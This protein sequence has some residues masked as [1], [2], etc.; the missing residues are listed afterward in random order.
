MVESLSATREGDG[1][2]DES[3]AA[4]EKK[5]KIEEENSPSSA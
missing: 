5:E 4:R 1:K 3:V 2:N